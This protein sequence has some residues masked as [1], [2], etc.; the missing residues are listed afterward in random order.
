MR[1]MKHLIL[2]SFPCNL[3]VCPPSL[4]AQGYTWAHFPIATWVLWFHFFLK[5][6]PNC[7]WESPGDMFT[8]FLYQ[9]HG[10]CHLLCGSVW[11]SVLTAVQ[12]L[13]SHSLTTVL[14]TDGAVVYG[15]FLRWEG[16]CSLPLCLIPLRTPWEVARTPQNY[17]WTP[18]GSLSCAQCGYVRTSRLHTM[19]FP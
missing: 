10:H 5:P 2:L 15:L 19:L 3:D 1:W 18:Y 11:L 9:A 8:V 6:T 4:L 16:E 7:L 13:S 17:T 14:G 12:I